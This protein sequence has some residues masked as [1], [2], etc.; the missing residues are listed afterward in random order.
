M[1]LTNIS[2]IPSYLCVMV[3]PLKH[4][5]LRYIKKKILYNFSEILIFQHHTRVLICLSGYLGVSFRPFRRLY[6]ITISIGDYYLP[7]IQELVIYRN[8]VDLLV[9]FFSILM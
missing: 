3:S 5:S 1:C 4:S 8:L 9:Y 7:F 6:V 2:S